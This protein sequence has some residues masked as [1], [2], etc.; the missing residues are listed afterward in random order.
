MSNFK[1]VCYTRTNAEWM[2]K[3]S[4]KENRQHVGDEKN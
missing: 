4:V 2:E 1:V 3:F